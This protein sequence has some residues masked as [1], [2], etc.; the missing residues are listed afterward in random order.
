[1]TIKAGVGRPMISKL[2]SAPESCGFP[3]CSYFKTT[4]RTISN[5]W[6]VFSLFINHIRRTILFNSH[7]RSSQ[8]APKE[9]ASSGSRGVEPPGTWGLKE[10]CSAVPAG[11]RMMPPQSC[12]DRLLFASRAPRPSLLVAE[13]RFPLES[14]HR[15]HSV[16]L[17][18]KWSQSYP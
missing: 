10:C 3:P 12:H 4:L 15:H 14:L 2:L 7:S 6:R 8:Y 16:S 17:W 9:V 1:M 18:F 5:I 11:R 13:P